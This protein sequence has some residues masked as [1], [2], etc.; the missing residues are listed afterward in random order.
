MKNPCAG[1]MLMALPLAV[2]EGKQA[3]HPDE[4]ATSSSEKPVFSL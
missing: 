3:Q 2:S 1:A 4:K